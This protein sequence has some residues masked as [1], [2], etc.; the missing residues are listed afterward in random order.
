MFY[1]G[2]HGEQ[3]RGVDPPPHGNLVSPDVSRTL[4]AF[5]AR[6]WEA[7]VRPRRLVRMADVFATVAQVV[8]LEMKGRLFVGRSLLTDSEHEK[9]A[10]FSF[11]RP[12]RL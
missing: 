11:Y 1:L 6:A 5:E 4:M 3:L 9:I 8:G 7:Q 10:S 2:D 12:G